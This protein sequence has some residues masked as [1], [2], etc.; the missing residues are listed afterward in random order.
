MEFW[1]VLAGAVALIAAVPFVRFLFKRLA[2]CR[3][4]KRVCRQRGYRFHTAHPFWLLGIRRAKHCELW[5]ET[6][7]AIFAIKLFGVLRRRRMLVFGEDGRYFFRSFRAFF[8]HMGPL[9]YPMNSRPRRLAVDWCFCPDVLPARKKPLRRVLLLHPVAMQTRWQAQRTGE[10]EL[11]DGECLDGVSFC[12]LPR[13]L[14]EL[15]MGK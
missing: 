5:I 15:R 3:R 2:C 8:A 11:L 6:A 1:I 10:R 14:D 7:D 12:S 13:L 9:F 4:L